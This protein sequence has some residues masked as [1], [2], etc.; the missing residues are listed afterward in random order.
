MDGFQFW[1]LIEQSRRG[2][3]GPRPEAGPVGGPWDP[4]DLPHLFPRLRTVED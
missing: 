1:W 4:A 2:L 3:D